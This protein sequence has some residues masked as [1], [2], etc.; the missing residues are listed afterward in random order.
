[1]VTAIIYLAIKEK[2]VSSGVQ[3]VHIPR[4]VTQDMLDTFTKWNPFGMLDT[5]HDRSL[6][7]PVRDI[8]PQD[9][10]VIS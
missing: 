4:W 10:A 5:W 3:Y 9:S 6:F 1:M 8:A 2:Y 7:S